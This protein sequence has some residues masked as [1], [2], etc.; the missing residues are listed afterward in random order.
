MSEFEWMGFAGLDNCANRNITKQERVSMFGNTN[1][2]SEI[3]S[4]G[5]LERPHCDRSLEM[6]LDKGNHPRMS[7]IQVNELCLIYLDIIRLWAVLYTAVF[8]FVHPE[9]LSGIVTASCGH[10]VLLKQ[11]PSRNQTWQWKMDHLSVI[12]LL[13]PPF[14]SGIFQPAMFD[15][16]AG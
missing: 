10:D 14:N 9:F 3:I 16:Q 11:I 13:R 2:S 15:D 1:Q 4:L 7:L 5:K 8:L 12:F 6:M